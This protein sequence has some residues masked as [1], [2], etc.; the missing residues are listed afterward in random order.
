MTKYHSRRDYPGAAQLLLAAAPLLS[1]GHAASAAFHGARGLARV[2]R[3]DEAIVGYHKVIA[4][5]PHSRYAAEA[6]YLA[7]WLDFNRGRFRESLPDLQATLDHFGKSDFADDAAWCLAFAH[8]LL[9]E[10]DQALAGFARYDKLPVN[11]GTG[12]ERRAR[13]NYWRSR[14]YEKTGRK[15]EAIAG[16]RESIK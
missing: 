6:Q 14:V 5:F 4:T 15:A 3:D 1:G 8:Y 9:G 2:D 7:G 11:D 12:D 16:Y 13:V 10:T